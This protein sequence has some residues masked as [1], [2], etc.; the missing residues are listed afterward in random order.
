[1]R[2]KRHTVSSDSGYI[3][4]SD[5]SSW[6]LPEVN[7]QI[8]KAWPACISGASQH[9]ISTLCGGN[10]AN[11]HI[12]IDQHIH[13]YTHTGWRQTLLVCD[14]LHEL[15]A[16]NISYLKRKVLS[17][18][19]LSSQLITSL[20]SQINFVIRAASMYFLAVYFYSFSFL[21]HNSICFSFIAFGVNQIDFSG[22]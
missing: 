7:T 13:M 19:L 8:P 20:R 14:V 1:M 18:H 2:W 9:L 3:D 11:S 21:N 17:Q 16:N 22:I 4:G 10:Q 6:S 12:I 5:K 15:K